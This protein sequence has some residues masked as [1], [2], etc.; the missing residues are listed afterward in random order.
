MRV[1]IRC[2]DHAAIGLG[3][4][5]RCLVL[6][7]ALRRAGDQVFFALRESQPGV[8][9]VEQDGFAYENGARLPDDPGGASWLL[10]LAREQQAEVVILDIR[11]DLP[12][13]CLEELKKRSVLIVTLDD[14]SERRLLADLAF[15]PPV[16]QVRTMDWR[17]FQGE[18]HT[19]WEW[20]LLQERFRNLPPRRERHNEIPRLLLTFG[21]SD[22][23]GLTL[24][25]LDL[26][27][28]ITCPFEPWLV[29][30]KAFCHSEALAKKLARSRRDYRIL[31]DVQDMAA[32]MAEADL[33]LAAGG[34]TG[35]ELA[36]VGVP[37][38]HIALTEDH[39]LACRELEKAGM[40]ICL[41]LWP[42]IQK[43]IEPVQETIQTWLVDAQKRAAARQRGR[44]LL[45]G[46]GAE[47]MAQAIQTYFQQRRPETNELS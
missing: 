29:L 16:P 11:D 28:E 45:D 13:A 41:G 39:F 19:G 6:A 26:L 7:R 10:Q 9:L 42:E 12:S 2:D 38:M 44:T 37:A 47:R 23:A 3:H 24:F 5:V 17:S 46:Y 32:V 27:E 35:Y 31:Q 15:Y 1:L 40:A 20:V 8:L 33:A 21:G 30:G 22:P 18:L 14:P 4:V 25:A 34:G 36:A 43:Q